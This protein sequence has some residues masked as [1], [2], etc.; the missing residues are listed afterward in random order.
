MSVDVKFGAQLLRACAIVEILNLRVEPLGLDAEVLLERQFDRL[1]H[2]EP[3]HVAVPAGDAGRLRAAPNC[4]DCPDSDT[5]ERTRAMRRRVPA[6]LPRRR[7]AGTREDPGN[8]VWR[9]SRHLQPL[10]REK[11]E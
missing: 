3:P 5:Q 7:F 1:V 9:S 4:P 8:S 11:R 2:R 6:A 10:H